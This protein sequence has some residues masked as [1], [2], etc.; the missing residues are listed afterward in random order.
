MSA[1]SG[2][3][4][5]LTLAEKGNPMIRYGKSPVLRQHQSHSR[6]S[7]LLV[8]IACFVRDLPLFFSAAPKTPLRVLCIIAFDTLH[9]LRDARAMPRPRLKVL[10]DLLDF[11]A[12]ANASLDGKKFCERAHDEARQRL[13]DA[14]LGSLVEDYVSELQ[15]LESRRPAPRGDHG[16]F[17]EVRAYRES[18]ARLSLEVIAAAAESREAAQLVRV[19]VHG[20]DGLEILFRIVMQ[21][22]IVDDVLDYTKDVSAGL[23]GF[24]TASASLSQALEWTAR[25]SH[26]YSQRRDLALCGDLFPLRMALLA[27][28]AVT[29]RIVR[30]RQ[31]YCRIF[32]VEVIPVK[33]E[34]FNAV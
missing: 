19:S 31:W 23:P 26:D 2:F 13:R 33:Q 27:V 22:Q 17:T 7:A 20:D 3:V 32:P 34:E 9:T 5:C 29:R 15:L 1:R 12:C 10:A 14:G 8:S 4:F 28:S 11:G 30:L 21:C 25:A 6:F 18:V 24:L 16:T